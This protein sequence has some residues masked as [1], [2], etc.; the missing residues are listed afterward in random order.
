M[1]RSSG[2][3]PLLS[4]LALGASWTTSSAQH[5]RRAVGTQHELKD[6]ALGV[7][8]GNPQPAIMGLNDR[9]A[10][11]QTHPHAARFCSEQRMEYVLEV[12]RADSCAGV[13]HRH[14]Y[15]PTAAH[16]GPDA[17]DPRSVLGGH[18]VDGVGDQVQKHLLQ[19]D[20]VSSYLRY[21]CIRL[22][23]DQYPVP[24]Q[25]AARQGGGF[26]DEV[27]DVERSSVS[28]VLLEHGTNASD[29]RPRAMAISDD[30]R[31]CRLRFLDIWHRAIK[32]AQA[33]IGVRN[34]PRQW[35]PDLVS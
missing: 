3:E 19:L 26:P 18:R 8:R 1:W 4:T 16:P 32:P 22:G 20:S 5:R 11:R 35:L 21:L 6:G 14:D 7:V 23:L 31:E 17:Q 33:R 30:P 34:H 10:D 29:H 28:G 25:I 9:T 27:G 13:R 24:L 12:L 2:S 15:V